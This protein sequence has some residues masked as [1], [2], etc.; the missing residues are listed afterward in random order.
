MSAVSQPIADFFTAQLAELT[1]FP[2]ALPRRPKLDFVFESVQDSDAYDSIRAVIKA[3]D[4][5]L[6][7]DFL[8]HRRE[9]TD[10]YT[11]H[12]RIH[13]DGRLELLENLEG[14]LGLPISGDRD[15]DAKAHAEIGRR[16]ARTRAIWRRKGLKP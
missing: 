11:L 14:Q 7:L 15:A 8:H 2:V 5:G 1:R 16:N 3:G 12:A 6:F 13:A 10:E 4:E 9:R